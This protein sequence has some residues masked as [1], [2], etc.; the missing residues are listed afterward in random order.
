METNVYNIDAE[1][2]AQAICCVFQSDLNP[3]VVASELSS[4]VLYH[5]NGATTMTTIRSASQFTE[6]RSTEL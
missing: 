6:E 1:R 4:K 2:V 5:S 3:V